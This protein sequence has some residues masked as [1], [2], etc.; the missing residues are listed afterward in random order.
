MRIRSYFFLEL[1]E[2][3]FSE[4]LLI[5]SSTLSYPNELQK[6][7]SIRAGR[8]ASQLGFDLLSAL[9]AYDPEKR[10]TAHQSLLHPWWE[11]EPKVSK[12]CVEALSWR[13]LFSVPMPCD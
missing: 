1:L 7:W 4:H 13:S 9:L 11:E 3:S 8:Q 2:S 12:E 6:W 10:I 5:A